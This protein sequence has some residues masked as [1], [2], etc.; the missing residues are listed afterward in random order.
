MGGN[1]AGAGGA[2]AKMGAA[3]KPQGLPHAPGGHPPDPGVEG[4]VVRGGLGG[5]LYKMEQVFGGGCA[6][7]TEY[8]RRTTKKKAAGAAL[9]YPCFKF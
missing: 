9:R 4:L 5:V 2:T 3:R 1:P 6:V 8:F 7:C